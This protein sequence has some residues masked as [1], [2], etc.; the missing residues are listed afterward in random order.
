MVGW[1]VSRPPVPPRPCAR[2]KESLWTHSSKASRS[3]Q[4]VMT[5]TSSSSSDLRTSMET[6]P[7]KHCTF[8]RL[9]AQRS[10]ISSA[11][12]SFTG[13]LLKIAIT[14]PSELLVGD[15]DAA[16]TDAFGHLERLEGLPHQL[17]RHLPVGRI[18]GDPGID[19]E[20]RPFLRQPSEHMLRQAEAA[21]SG[22]AGHNDADL[23]VAEAGE[24]GAFWRRL[25]HGFYERAQYLSGAFD[26][27]RRD[28]LGKVGDV[29][30]HHGEPLVRVDG[31]WQEQP[32]EL[33][34]VG[35]PG[36]EVRGG[37]PAEGLLH[38]APYDSVEGLETRLR[39]P[40]RGLHQ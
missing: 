1:P 24:G 27:P 38:L 25:L 34:P 26:L 10:T 31:P 28:G 22:L 39:Q 19:L 23:V 15:D 37:G 29:E 5:R 21:L 18:L 2:R 6:N 14:F 40:V 36:H 7:G 33:V 35:K 30:D 16:A 8:P 3:R 9:S 11:A 17:P 20:V 13:R 4:R 32:V 12:S